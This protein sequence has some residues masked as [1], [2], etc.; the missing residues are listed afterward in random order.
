MSV[1][2]QLEFDSATGACIQQAP[3]FLSLENPR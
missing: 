2:Y 1:N 3:A